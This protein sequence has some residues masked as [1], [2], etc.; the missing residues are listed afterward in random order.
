MIFSPLAAAAI[1]LAA[2]TLETHFFARATAEHPRHSEAAVIELK[3]GSLFIAWQ[4]YNPG[5]KGDSDFAPNHILSRVSQDGGRTWGDERMLVRTG[6]DE[7]NVYSA[8]LVRLP[9][10]EI[11]LSFMRNYK[12]AKAGDHDYPPSA[13]ECW[14]SADEGQTWQPRGVIWKE[15]QAQFAS[16]T[17]KRLSTGRLVV[18]ISADVG[19]KGGQHWQAGAAYS[20]DGG[21][22]WRVSGK[23]AE[24][25]RRGAME[26]QI[27]ELK[28]KRLLMVMRT[29]MGA[30]WRSHSAD[31]GQTWSPGESTGI[32]APES[33]PNLTRIP[34]TGDLLLIYNPV[35]DPKWVSHGGKRTP[36][37]AAVSKDDGRTWSKPRAVETD[38]DHAFTNPGTAFTRSGKAVVNYWTSKYT[39]KGYIGDERISLKLAII[40]VGWFYAKE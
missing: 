5:H 37:A 14:A 1:L 21:K 18:P 28:D 26:P 20:D 32:E 23:L 39:P 6:P 29:Q 2:P 7:I 34:S 27:E 33:C 40:D 31:G 16:S 8:G 11:V 9:S 17:L 35:H 15:M 4:Q 12:F 30:I 22:T 36:L 10:G 13:A 24:V 3:D 19:K 38:P 25:P